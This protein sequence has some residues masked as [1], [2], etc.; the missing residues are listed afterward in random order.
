MPSWRGD[1]G[2]SFLELL[3]VLAL[4]GIIAAFAV[5]RLMRAKAASNES[6]AIASLRA[7][8]AS[9][10][11]FINSCGRGGFAVSLLVLGSPPPG[12]MIPFL[13]A[14]LATSATPQKS[15][16][17]YTLGPAAGTAAVMNDCHG[18]PT[19]TGFYA[20]AQP[21]TFGVSG[22]RSFAL[23]TSQ[24]LWQLTASA[25]PTEPFGAPAAPVQ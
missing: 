1:D 21:L 25:A 23:N 18:N 17:Q 20:T 19:Q 15:G 13:S 3:I 24:V 8:A 5:P 22:Q 14:D 6:S 2:V 9:E 10:N 7:V 16:Y 4:I 11:L 12:E